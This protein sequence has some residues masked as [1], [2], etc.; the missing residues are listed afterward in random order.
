MLWGTLINL[1]LVAYLPTT[2]SMFISTIGLQWEDTG[3]YENAI[4]ANNVWTIFMLNVWILCPLIL[5]IVFYKNRDK[6]GTLKKDAKPDCDASKIK[7]RKDWVMY[8]ELAQKA[9][10]NPRGVIDACKNKGKNKLAGQDM[11]N[12]KRVAPGFEENEDPALVQ[13]NVIAQQLEGG[14][15]E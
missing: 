7:W 15:E 8:Q 10:K 14:E 4:L 1:I 6:V 5:F 13:N 3:D 9:S 12:S 11:V 2:M